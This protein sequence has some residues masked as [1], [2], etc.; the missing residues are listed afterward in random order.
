M[1][2]LALAQDVPTG[3]LAASV[4]FKQNLTGRDE[5]WISF[6]LKSVCPSKFQLPHDRHFC[7]CFFASDFVF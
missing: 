4:P 7:L 3:R 5:V 1:M 6:F 2:M